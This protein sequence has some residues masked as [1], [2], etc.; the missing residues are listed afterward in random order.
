MSDIVQIIHKFSTCAYLKDRQGGVRVTLVREPNRTLKSLMEHLI[1]TDPNANEEDWASYFLQ[2]L[3]KAPT[4]YRIFFVSNATLSTIYAYTIYLKFC[5]D[6][7]FSYLQFPCW[8]AARKVSNQLSSSSK[9]YLHYSLED[10][11]LIAS[12]SALK[13]ASLL[14]S[15]DFKSGFSL[16]AYART[17]L[18]RVIKNQIA[19]ELK[20]K[21][22][23]F[24]DN[25]LLRN[26]SKTKLEKALIA[27]GVSTSNLE[28]YCLAWQSFND[29][30]EEIYPPTSSDGSRNQHP[31]TTPLN[32]QQLEQ[33]ALRYSQLLRRLEIG[34]KP[35]NGQEIQQMLTICV[36][37]ARTFQNKRLVS[38]EEGSEVNYAV[39]S[40]LETMI[41]AEKQTELAQIRKAILAGLQTLDQFAQKA[42]MLWLGLEINQKDFLSLL[43]LQKQYQVAR[44]FQRYQKTILKAVIQFYLQKNTEEQLTEQAI[45]RI[46][47]DKLTEMKDYLVVYSKDFFGKM[48]TAILAETHREAKLILIQELDDSASSVTQKANQIF[49]FLNY[50]TPLQSIKQ[51]IQEK[52]ESLIEK[53]LQIQLALFSSAPESIA[54]FIEQWLQKNAAILY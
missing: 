17:A 35:V 31:P 32:N 49:G 28:K 48:L 25:G 6:L 45:N 38:L 52:F 2:G 13:P 46:C 50:A 43:N 19:K 26:L 5:N 51:K 42:L 27:Y 20:T 39:S 15:F 10:C 30:F 8:D 54:R 1:E 21:S 3:I 29:F 34:S 9:S 36:Q 23:K 53:N 22:V 24:S 7:L 47:A 12:E 40:S 44:Q 37:A 18:L 16:G 14:K 11:F 41:E 33:V 4:L